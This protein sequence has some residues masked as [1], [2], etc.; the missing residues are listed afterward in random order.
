MQSF[1]TLGD[2]GSH[3]NRCCPDSKT[4]PLGAAWCSV[5]PFTVGVIYAM[6]LLFLCG[7]DTKGEGPGQC[8]RISDASRVKDLCLTGMSFEDFPYRHEETVPS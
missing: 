8:P 2:Y 4:D 5:S 6:S 7:K 1:C 3:S